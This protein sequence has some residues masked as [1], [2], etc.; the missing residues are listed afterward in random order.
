MRSE[1]RRKGPPSVLGPTVEVPR[2]IP[3]CNTT[4]MCRT[5]SS[6]V[7]QALSCDL[8]PESHR[9]AAGRPVTLSGGTWGHRLHS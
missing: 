3:G 6:K 2:L 8:S 5:L 9:R 1:G 7:G 4:L